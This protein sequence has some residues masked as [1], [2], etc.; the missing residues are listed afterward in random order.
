VWLIQAHAPVK[1]G[2]LRYNA[3]KLESTGLN[4]WKIFV[5][6]EIAPYF[7]Y[8]NEPWDIRIMEQGTGKAGQKRA[9]I[10]TWKNPNEGWWNDAVEAAIQLIAMLLPTVRTERF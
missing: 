3:I 4:G 2:N 7:I 1:T 8:T 9:V 5:N 6:E 10:R